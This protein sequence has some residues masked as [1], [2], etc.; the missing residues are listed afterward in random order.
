MELAETD[1]YLFW[2]YVKEF[3]MARGISEKSISSNTQNPGKLTSIEPRSTEDYIENPNSF[4]R[5]GTGCQRP[6]PARMNEGPSGIPEGP[7]LYDPPAS[8]LEHDP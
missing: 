4:S 7:S 1:I 5:S 3:A 2:H 8:L 6:A